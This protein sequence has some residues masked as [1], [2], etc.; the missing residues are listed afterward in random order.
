LAT[1]SVPILPLAAG[2]VLDDEL[3]AEAIRQPL[4]HQARLDVG[5]PARGKA[6][7]DADRPGRIGFRPRHPGHG[8]QR[9]STP[10]PAARMCDA[11]I[12]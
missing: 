5:S 6:D 11:E 8:R 7:D 1:A 2:A 10:R 3:L 4:A 12:S 9:R